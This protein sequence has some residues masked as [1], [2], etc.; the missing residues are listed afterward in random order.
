[1]EINFDEK[2][3]DDEG[4]AADSGNEEIVNR[5]AILEARPREPSS[6]PDN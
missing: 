6:L 1:L 2:A 3:G 4:S 5:L